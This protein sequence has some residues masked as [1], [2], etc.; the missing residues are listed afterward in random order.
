M[1]EVWTLEIW[2]RPTHGANTGRSCAWTIRATLAETSG[3][4]E[5]CSPLMTAFTVSSVTTAYRPLPSSQS[6]DGQY[7]PAMTWRGSVGLTI[8]TD[9]FEMSEVSR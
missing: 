3:V 8:V 6:F 2:H 9:Y 7:E 1:G 4:P 5:L